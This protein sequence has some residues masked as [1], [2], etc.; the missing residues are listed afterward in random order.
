VTDY[1]FFFSLFNFLFSLGLS[2][3]FF[4]FSLFPL[5]LLPPS[6]MF[7]SPVLDRVIPIVIPTMGVHIMSRDYTQT[8]QFHNT[9]LLFDGFRYNLIFWVALREL[10][11]R[12]DAC[13]THGGLRK[14]R[15]RRDACGTIVGFILSKRHKIPVRMWFESSIIGD[16]FGG[17]G[18]NKYI[19]W[20]IMGQG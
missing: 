2:W 12:R 4:W 9:I 1:L 16:I 10:R 20:H 11:S 7:V 17:C 6:A 15:S 18:G 3:A 19:N 8:R 13:D 5:S 14:L